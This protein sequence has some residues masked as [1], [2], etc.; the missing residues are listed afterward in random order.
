MMRRSVEIPRDLIHR[1]LFAPPARPHPPEMMK[2]VE[3]VAQVEKE[4]PPKV[5][6]EKL[7]KKKREKENQ[8]D[9]RKTRTRT[10]AHEEIRLG[11]DDE[12]KSFQ[13]S[14]DKPRELTLLQIKHASLEN[15]RQSDSGST[16]SKSDDAFEVEED[17][18]SSH[19]IPRSLTDSPRKRFSDKHA[20]EEESPRRTRSNS[21]SRKGNSCV[22]CG[23]RFTSASLFQRYCPVCSHPTN[24]GALVTLDD[25]G[26][27]SYDLLASSA[28]LPSSSPSSSPK[29]NHVLKKAISRTF[30]TVDVNRR[31]VTPPSSPLT[32]RFNL[33]SSSASASSSLISASL[34][35]SSSESSVTDYYAPIRSFSDNTQSSS[36]SQV[37]ASSDH[38]VDVHANK[39]NEGA[40]PLDDSRDD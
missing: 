6:K 29:P 27:K 25:S 40:E 38:K 11:K 22:N 34:S 32:P 23:T 20:S 16:E 30:T 2:E 9:L 39:E 19:P 26:D 33:P 21:G 37:A 31:K 7:E 28:V 35:K 10:Y 1:E 5:K 12:I 14:E 17:R 15:I 3:L 18:S 36:T 8:K 13:V 24:T 4:N